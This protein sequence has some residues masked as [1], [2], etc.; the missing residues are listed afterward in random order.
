MT[1]NYLGSISADDLPATL[2]NFFW[3]R[4]QLAFQAPQMTT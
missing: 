3:N 2:Q 4:Y 1:I